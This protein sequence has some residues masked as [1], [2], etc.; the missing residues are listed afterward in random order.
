MS[1]PVPCAR[2]GQIISAA[3]GKQVG[4]LSAMIS[5]VLEHMLVLTPYTRAYVHMPL[6]NMDSAMIYPHNPVSNDETS[7]ALHKPIVKPLLAAVPPVAESN[8]ML[9]HSGPIEDQ[10]SHITYCSALPFY[11]ENAYPHVYSETI[12]ASREADSAS[13]TE[14]VLHFF[15]GLGRVW[16]G[17]PESHKHDWSWMLRVLQLL[18]QGIEE[19]VYRESH[20][21][22]LTYARTNFVLFARLARYLNNPATRILQNTKIVSDHNDLNDAQ[23]DALK[24][25]ERAGFTIAA[26]VNDL[27]DMIALQRGTIQLDEDAL[28]LRTCIHNALQVTRHEAKRKGICISET[29]AIQVPSLI[30]GDATR[31]EQIVVNLLS[32]AIRFT[33]VG[34]VYLHVFVDH[35]D[36]ANRLLTKSHDHF[37]LSEYGQPPVVLTVSVKDTGVGIASDKIERVFYA[38]RTLPETPTERELDSF[39]GIGVGLAICRALVELMGGR[40]WVR[41]RHG[42]GSTFSFSFV[43]RRYVDMAQTKAQWHN[44]LD[45]KTVLVLCRETDARET[46]YDAFLFN[47]DVHLVAYHTLSK[48]IH[49][50]RRR[51]RPVH[52]LLV[53][54]TYSR[55]TIAQLVKLLP[56]TPCIGLVQPNEP[57]G[58]F[59]THVIRYPLTTYHIMETTTHALLT[60]QP[61][62]EPENLRILVVM[63]DAAAQQQIV[64]VLS[65]LGYAHSDIDVTHNIET[66][67]RHLQ[68]R[69]YDVILAHSERNAIE[70]LNA[71]P[72]VNRII[73]IALLDPN[74]SPTSSERLKNLMLYLHMP[75]KYSEMRIMLETVKREQERL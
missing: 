53:D 16:L 23:F 25:M 35:S 10:Y 42:M 52:A 75:V 15:N 62:M 57:T 71:I 13:A 5:H 8:D 45:N 74:T 73:V 29:V 7:P 20:R 58:E 6:L 21:R 66:A 51:Q 47:T 24:C 49:Y 2:I 68:Q 64:E 12:L 50:V 36:E 56:R 63:A 30:L 33:D 61:V 27:S 55:D 11:D 26:V 70:K 9:S 67:E 69:H 48:A 65:R 44:T 39:H 19:C 38:Y 34:S 22:M 32:N 72:H 59:F 4:G 46:I 14:A 3:R 41:S 1:T 40:M 43:T 60:H 37:G 17:D 31:L 28:N 54:A 18:T